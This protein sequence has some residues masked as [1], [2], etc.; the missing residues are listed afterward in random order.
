MHRVGPIV[1]RKNRFGVDAWGTVDAGVRDILAPIE[2]LFEREFPRYQPF[3]FG[4]R[5]HIAQ[6]VRHML[7]AEPLVEEWAEQ[8]QGLT[9]DDID[10]LMRSFAFDQCRVRAELAEIL[11]SG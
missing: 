8:F 5:R 11:A 2:A 9:A 7:L 10:G 1:A 6:L 4:A 3:P